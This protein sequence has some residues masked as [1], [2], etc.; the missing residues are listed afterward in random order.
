[1]CVTR[2]KKVV[3]SKGI[4]FGLS[5]SLW[6][7][8]VLKR[9]LTMSPVPLVDFSRNPLKAKGIKDISPSDN[10]RVRTVCTGLRRPEKDTGIA[11]LDST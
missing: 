1:M 4:H 7:S 6:R 9:I 5:L 11:S 8:L 3:L 2:K 10:A